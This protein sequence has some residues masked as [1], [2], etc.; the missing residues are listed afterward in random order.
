MHLPEDE[1]RPVGDTVAKAGGS[2]AVGEDLAFQRRWWKFERGVWIVFALILLAD[3]SGLLGRGPL[4]KKEGHTADGSLLVKYE[5]VERANTPS[6]MTVLP[7]ATAIQN[8]ALRLFVSDSMVDR[9]G[10]QRVI[11]SPVLSTIGNGGVTY[12]FPATSLPMT[13]QFA[14]Q[15]SFIGSHAFRVGVAGQDTVQ[16]KIFVLP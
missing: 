10:T 13:V 5:S 1:K 15:P 11:P 9:L 14:L 4:S 6:I 12:T 16:G 7:G 3:L 2:V 8:G